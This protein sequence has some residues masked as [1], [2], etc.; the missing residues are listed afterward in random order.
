MNGIDSSTEHRR[1]EQMLPVPEKFDAFINSDFERESD[2]NSNDS[3]ASKKSNPPYQPDNN[4]I[5]S[6]ICALKSPCVTAIRKYRS[7]F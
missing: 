1:I 2:P 4:I 7:E 6:P 3:R 5:P